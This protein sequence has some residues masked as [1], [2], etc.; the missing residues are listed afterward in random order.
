[1]AHSFLAADRDELLLMPASS[2]EWLPA[3]HLA[4]FVLDVVA[5]A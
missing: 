4:W 5:G 2:A 3:D 1:V